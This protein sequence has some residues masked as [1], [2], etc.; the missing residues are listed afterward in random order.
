MPNRSSSS[1]SSGWPRMSTGNGA[2][3]PGVPPAGT[4]TPRPGGEHGGEQPVGHPDLD[5]VMAEAASVTGR[6]SGPS[7]PK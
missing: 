3:K 7:P 6:A 4:I 2:R 1:A 5:G